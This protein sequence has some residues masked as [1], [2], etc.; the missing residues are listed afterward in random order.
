MAAQTKQSADAGDALDSA[1]ALQTTLDSRLAQSS[2]V[3]IDEE[4]TRMLT[5]QGAYAANARIIAAVQ[6]MMDQTL[7]M[8]R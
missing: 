6:T 1:Q 5:L 8:L 2:A 3:N 4:M 7:Q